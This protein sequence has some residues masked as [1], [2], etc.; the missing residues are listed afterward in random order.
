MGYKLRW[1][2]E[3]VKNLEEILSDIELKWTERELNN[4]KKQAK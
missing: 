2:E 4:F 1:S 3:S